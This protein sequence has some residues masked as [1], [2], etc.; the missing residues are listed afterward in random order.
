MLTT[1]PHSSL[2]HNHDDD[3]FAH[4]RLSLLR[5][6]ARLGA[7]RTQTRTV[8]TLKDHKVRWRIHPTTNRK[9][10]L[11]S[12]PRTPRR[13]GRAAMARSYRTTTAG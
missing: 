3:M 11:R 1:S 2:V 5:A 12:T 7:A 8:T 13:A 10:T 9:L 6:Q 4:A